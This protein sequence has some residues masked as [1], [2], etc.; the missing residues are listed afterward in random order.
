MGKFSS[1]LHI[2]LTWRRQIVSCLGVSGFTTKLRGCKELEYNLMK[3]TTK[4]MMMMMMMM[5]TKIMMRKMMSVLPP[6]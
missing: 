3:I 2:V 5:M 1:K 4:T 6:E